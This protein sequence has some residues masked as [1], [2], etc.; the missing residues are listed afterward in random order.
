MGDLTVT[1]E[2]V[3]G[4]TIRVEYEPYT[5]LFNPRE[6]D[7]LGVMVCSHRRYNLGD[8]QAPSPDDYSGVYGY[9]SVRNWLIAEHDAIA[10]TILPLYLFDHSGLSMSTSSATFRAF[11]SAGWDWGIVG[12]IFATPTTVEAMGTPEDR[13]VEGLRQEVETYDQY[14]RGE[15]F[16]WL[17]EDGDGNVLE[18]CGG[19][20]GESDYAL[21]EARATVEHLPAYRREVVGAFA[22]SEGLGL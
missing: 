9:G 13:V 16:S 10:E 18:S 20:I 4:L 7:N 15:V 14:L 8:E 5:D 1:E 2:K 19:Y 17:I 3:G 22:G 11:D 6:Y 12:F 21:S